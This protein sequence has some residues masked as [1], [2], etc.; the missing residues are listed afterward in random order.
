MVPRSRNGPVLGLA[1]LAW[2]KALID[3]H[4][5]DHLKVLVSCIG[6]VVSLGLQKTGNPIGEPCELGGRPGS[7]ADCGCVA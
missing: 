2:Y 4:E 1:S 7:M 3:S 6:T 5:F